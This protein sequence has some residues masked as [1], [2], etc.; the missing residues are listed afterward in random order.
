MRLPLTPTRALV[1]SSSRFRS[2]ILRGYK[3]GLLPVYA[4]WQ[5]LNR[6]ASVLRI[7]RHLTTSISR[8]PMDPPLLGHTIPE[9]LASIVATH[10][11]RTA[12]KS[13]L[14][15]LHPRSVPAAWP[16]GLPSSSVSLSFE[17][18]DRISNYLAH[19]LREHGVKKGDPVAVSLGNCW[20][21]AALTYAIFKMGAILV[22]LNPQFNSKQVTAALNHLGVKLL[23]INA[24]T[25]LPYKPCLGRNNIDL[26]QTLVPDLESKHWRSPTVPSLQKIVVVDNSPSHV[27]SNFPDLK[28][29]PA[30]T[31]FPLDHANPGENIDGSRFVPDAP[32]SPSDTINIQFT[33]GTTSHPKAAMLTHT[34]ILN[35]GHMIGQRMGLIPEDRIVCPPPLFHCFG[36]ILG[37]MA[38]ATNGSAIMFPSPA[39]DPLATLLM[40]QESEATGL[41]GVATMFIAVLEELAAVTPSSP[42]YDADRVNDLKKQPFTRLR[43]GIGAGSSVPESLMLRLYDKLGLEELVI[44]YGMTETSPVSCMTTPHDPFIKRTTTVGRVMPHTTVKV[45]DP[46]DN[47]KIVPRGERG[48]LA[49]AGYLIMKGYWGDEERTNQVRVTEKD[50]E[51]GQETVWMYTGDEAVMDEDG[52]VAITGRIK[53]LIIRGGEN[54]HPLEIENCLL[55][56]ELVAD[57]SVVGV[58]DEKYGESVG[59]FVIAHHEG[60]EAEGSES[61]KEVGEQGK[62]VLTAEMVREWVRTHLSGHLVPKHVWFVKDYPKTASGKIQKFKLRDWA[63]KHLEE[64]EAKAP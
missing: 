59:V 55:Q 41:Y 44:C 7:N 58:P 56:H 28:T 40:C 17:E 30:L 22:P 24:V 62:K 47:T 19:T 3:R 12:V 4:Q 15:K 6:T 25:D 21:F 50:D 26:L 8:G 42:M 35:N 29:L 52:Y 57:A 46:L 16:S 64:A 11:K 33:S 39:F 36:S 53:D 43:K 18:L 5:S 60:V 13:L 27:F 10:P 51:N 34:S 38:T 31:P 32:L 54:I 48:E 45:V 1:T 61:E 9:H 20:E 14:P 49:T 2:G 63:K 37:Y 23:I